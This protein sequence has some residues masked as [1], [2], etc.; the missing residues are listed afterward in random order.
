M[1]GPRAFDDL[2]GWR[3]LA[4]YGF[5]ESRHFRLQARFGL[6]LSEPLDQLRGLDERVVGDRG[7]RSVTAPATHAQDERRAHLLGSRREVERA[8]SELDAVASSLVQ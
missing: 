8:P 5:H 7:H 4:G 1:N 3:N 6:E 2:I